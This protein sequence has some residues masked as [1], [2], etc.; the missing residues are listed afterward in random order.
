MAMHHRRAGLLALQQV[1]LIFIPLFFSL[2]ECDIS[3]ELTC[4]GL[5]SSG[6]DACKTGFVK[7]DGSCEG[8]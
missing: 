3:C 1:L 2:S 4:T 5:G 8:K 7:K 6:C